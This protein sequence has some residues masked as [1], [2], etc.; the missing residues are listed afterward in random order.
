MK[1]DMINASVHGRLG[2]D[3]VERSTRAG[4][5]M[6]TCSVAVNVGRPGESEATEWVSLA[7]F[8]KNG[9]LLARHLKGDVVAVMGP[10]HRT[11]FTGRDGQARTNWSLTVESLVSARSARPGGGAADKKRA[12]AALFG[13]PRGQS[14]LPDDGVDDLYNEIVP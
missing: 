7:A 4:K 9:E 10:L 12:A 5:P 6:T 8:G 14:R 2:G 13:A 1:V 3:P 11:T